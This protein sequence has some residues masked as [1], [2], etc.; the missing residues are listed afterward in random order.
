MHVK[1]RRC[2]PFRIS[3]VRGAVASAMMDVEPAR[4]L[5]LED[6]ELRELAERRC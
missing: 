1:A 4:H 6:R 2:E 3:G 5:R